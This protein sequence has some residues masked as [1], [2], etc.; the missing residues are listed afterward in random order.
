MALIAYCISSA[1]MLAKVA[2][3]GEQLD[4]DE[5]H[6]QELQLALAQSGE[7]IDAAEK[8]LRCKTPVGPDAEKS[9][10]GYVSVVIVSNTKQINSYVS[11]FIETV[12][13]QAA[14]TNQ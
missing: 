14:Y 13:I 12:T 3:Q 1:E 8:E 11:F 2:E 4:E 5:L 9:L 7:K 6:L 10:T